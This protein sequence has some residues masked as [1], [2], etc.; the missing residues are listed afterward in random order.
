VDPAAPADPADPAGKDNAGSAFLLT[1]R[2]PPDYR[3]WRQPMEEP[4][5]QRA[6]VLAAAVAAALMVPCLVAAP[7][8]AEDPVEKKLGWFDAAELSFVSTS[9][10]SN[11]T[12]LGFR[13]E[14]KRVWSDAELLV[15][16]GS[17]YSEARPSERF[18]VG[19]TGEGNFSVEQGPHETDT[20]RLYGKAGYG[21]D[22]NPFLFWNVAGDAERNP[23]AGI[24]YRYTVGAGLG[25][26]WVRQEKVKFRT[27]YNIT[28]TNENFT[29][30]DSQDFPG[31]RLGYNYEN[32][33]TPTTLFESNLLFDDSFDD[34]SDH[35]TDW[36]N[37]VTVSMT[38]KI[39]LKVGYRILYRN[40]P[41]LEEIK[42]YDAN[43]YDGPANEVG[44][45]QVEK[46]NLDTNFTTS[47]VFNF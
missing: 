26:N 6:G 37:A 42:I 30:G 32:K 21:R 35:R 27:T 40:I 11:S 2:A 44:T 45:D 46:E 23:P 28:Y 29:N 34:F 19:A 16:I 33:L 8:F 47:L 9:G 10:N 15:E 22:L 7:A 24:D 20:N 18:G 41:P 25:N 38:Q 39:A 14:T 3:R 4:M 17:V 36:Y 31:F 5:N 13:N 43:P 12:T 1:C